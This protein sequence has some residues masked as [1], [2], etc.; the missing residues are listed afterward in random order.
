[1]KARLQR[2][3]EWPFR[4]PEMFEALGIPALRGILLHGP[5]GCSKTT[6]VRA[7]ATA[8]EATFITASP[9]Q[10][11]SSYVGDAERTI[12]Q[13]FGLARRTA[14]AVVFFDEIDA[15]VS[16]RSVDGDRSGGVQQRLLATLLNEMDGVDRVAGVLVVAATNRIDIIDPALLRPG[17]FDQIVHVDTP[18]SLQD[19]AAILEVHTARMP[20]APD[21]DLQDLAQ[22]TVLAK[23][24]GADIGALCREAAMHSLRELEGSSIGTGSN[25]VVRPRAHCCVL[26][27]PPSQLVRCCRR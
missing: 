9:A 3:I 19:H 11:M 23:S 20:L 27:H 2:Y 21:V 10:V 18:T 12:R 15:L 13:I 1:M 26:M 16:T 6:L 25:V 22:R 24:T 5:P 8:S 7:V 4:Y 14:P 17:R